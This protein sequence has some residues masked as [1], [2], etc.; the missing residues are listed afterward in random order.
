MSEAAPEPSSVPLVL[1]VDDD[2]LTRTQ[3]RDQLEAQGCAVADASSGIEA[4]AAFGSLTASHAG[5][6][7][8]MVAMHWGTFVLTDEAPDE[9]P[10][11]IVEAWERERRP[12]ERL[13][14]LA[15]G[16]T[17]SLSSAP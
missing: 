7:T 13:W 17:R 9:P 1:V 14:V 2:R 6:P 16:E 5:H 8:V 12:A 4:L 10:R 3:L 15:P 11:R